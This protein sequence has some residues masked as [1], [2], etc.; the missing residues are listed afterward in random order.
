MIQ[1]PTCV[2]LVLCEKFVVEESSRKITLVNCFQRLTASELP[3]TAEPFYLYVCLTDGIGAGKLLLE[4]T[5]TESTGNVHEQ[6]VMIEFRNPTKRKR[7]VFSIRGCTFASP[8][9]YQATLTADKEL[10]ALAVFDVEL[11][12]DQ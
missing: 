9:R 6:F 10:V 8:G 2:G 5:N 3:W 12:E 11:V 7:F 1:T 4:I